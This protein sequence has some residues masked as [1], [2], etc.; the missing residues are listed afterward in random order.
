LTDAIEQGAWEY[1]EKIAAMGGALRA[2]E[3][4]YVQAEIQDAAYRQQVAIERGEQVVV[5]VNRFRQEDEQPIAAFRVEPALERQQIE[6]LREVRASRSQAAVAGALANLERAAR[7]TD[8]LM[9]LILDAAGAYATVGEISDKL[10]SVF[11][12]YTEAA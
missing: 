7:G 12:E 3:R 8:N 2:I 1:L 6:R 10:R 9:P 11:G 4:G 5:G